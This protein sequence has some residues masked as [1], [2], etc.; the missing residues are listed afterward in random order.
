MNVLLTR[1]LFALG[2]IAVV[3]IPGAWA[4]CLAWLWYQRR[5]ARR[6]APAAATDPVE[7]RRA[8]PDRACGVLP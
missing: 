6:V 1:M 7:T 3:V 2:V 5:V 8:A 4:V